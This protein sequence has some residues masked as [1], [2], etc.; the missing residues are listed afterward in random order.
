MNWHMP[1][2]DHLTKM[3]NSIFLTILRISTAAFLMGAFVNLLNNRPFINIVY[4]MIA[5]VFIFILDYLY[6]S[7]NKNLVRLVFLLFLCVGYLPIA[8]LTSPGSYS[9]MSFYAVLLLFICYIVIQKTWEYLFPI[10]FTITTILLLH[11]ELLRPDQYTF[12]TDPQH[13]AFDLSLNF[14]LVSITLFAL[15]FIL[16]NSFS[17][18]HARVYRF[19][20]TDPLTNLYNRRYLHHFLTRIMENNMI[21]PISYSL[22]LMDLDNFKQV[23]DLYGHP[24][25]DFVLKEFARVLETASRKNDIVIRFGGDEFLLLLM[26]TN[27]EGITLVENRIKDL[28]HPICLKYPTIPLSV[29]FGKA[30]CSSETADE[31]IKLADDVLYNN[32]DA[33]KKRVA[34]IK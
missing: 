10:L 11:M 6:R 2:N 31:V 13:R 19:S 26:D 1:Q 3:K 29:S 17:D 18:E 15:I 24:E 20:I 23:N 5:A 32:K 22:L 27:E 14:L 25:G 16:N 8:W 9:A 34:S 12:Y 28:F 30:T 7:C 33:S 4:P 21:S